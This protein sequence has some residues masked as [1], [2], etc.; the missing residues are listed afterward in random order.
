MKR[1]LSSLFVLFAV[2]GSVLAGMPMHSSLM[3]NKMMKCC[4]KAKGTEQ[5]P[6]ASAARLCCAVNCSDPVP[7]SAVTSFNF[8]PAIV[9]VTEAIEK[10]VAEL[11]GRRSHFAVHL[12][13]KEIPRLIQASHPKYLQHHSFLI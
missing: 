4:K 5:S 10:Q 11:L 1:L 3:D 9:K 13:S 8:A 12:V 2:A 6:S 7:T